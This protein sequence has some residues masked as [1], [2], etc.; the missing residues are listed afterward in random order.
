MSQLDESRAGLNASEAAIAWAYGRFGGDPEA[1][2]VLEADAAKSIR[3]VV[4]PL[5]EADEAQ[6]ISLVERWRGEDRRWDCIEELIDRVDGDALGRE[7]ACMP[8]RWQQAL[9]RITNRSD[10]KECPWYDNSVRTRRAIVWLTAAPLGKYVPLRRPE[11]RERGGFELDA[12]VDMQP[13]EREDFIRRLGVFQLA[14]LARQQDRRN[15]ARLRRA[16]DI[17]DRRWFDECIRRERSIERLERGRL[18]ELF[19]AVSRQEP[20]L[21][22][23]LLHLGLYSMAAG[24]GERFSAKLQSVAEQ[25]PSALCTLLLHYHRCEISSGTSALAPAFRGALDE[26]VSR[27]QPESSKSIHADSIQMEKSHE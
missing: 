12:L 25:L 11:L 1:I 19:L 10:F 4:E 27:Y 13:L 2:D 20:D 8:P 16:L 18:R 7:A 3:K 6:R 21:G 23:R 26:F 9:E 5:L 14:E 24:A 17:G 22:A 15:L